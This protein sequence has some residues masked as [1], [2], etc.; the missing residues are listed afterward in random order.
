[1]SR[2]AVTV[3]GHD[4][5]GIVADVTGALAEHG[6]NIEDSSMTLLRGHFA[7]TLIVDI[8]DATAADLDQ[9]LANVN[10]DRLKVAVIELADE[11][12]ADEQAADYWLTVHGADRPGIVSA[13]TRVVAEVGGNLTN[14][15]TRLAGGMYVV[16]ADVDFPTGVNVQQVT[17]Q[18]TTTATELGVVAALRPADSDVL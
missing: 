16:G 11:D 14:L 2:F 5:P 1:M 6:G 12:D 7:W 3:V 13:V 17:E 10:A 15:T 9:T 4:R 8:P 18:L